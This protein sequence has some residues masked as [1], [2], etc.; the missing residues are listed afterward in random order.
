MF[1]C[2]RCQ[3]SAWQ[4][5]KIVVERKTVTHATAPHGPRGSI[6]QQIV[7]EIVVCDACAAGI[8]EAP[9]ERNVVE[10]AKKPS[11]AATMALAA[12]VQEYVQ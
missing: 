4:P 9:I 2:E 12:T 6:G 10:R 7:K 5:R 8:A 3:S 1:K 11:S